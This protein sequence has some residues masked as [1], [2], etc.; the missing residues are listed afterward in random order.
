[1]KKL[2]A[3]SLVVGLGLV[4]HIPTAQACRRWHRNNCAAPVACAPA[5]AAATPSATTPPSGAGS[6]AT[7]I[8]SIPSIP[9]IP[10]VP[11]VPKIPDVPKLPATPAAPVP[12]PAAAPA[13]EAAPA[14]PAPQPAAAP[15][16]EKK[17]VAQNFRVWTDITGSRT[18]TARFLALEGQA[19]IRLER[20]SGKICRV[21]LANLSQADREY[22][23]SLTSVSLR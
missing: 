18:A 23:E 11:E 20:E 9:A 16:E 12:A 1:M 8:P 3:L 5:A 10:K 15:A 22:V 2:I 17:E 6:A 7:T 14:P 4:W 21:A 19:S 13:P